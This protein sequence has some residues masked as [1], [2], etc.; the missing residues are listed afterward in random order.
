MRRE[1]LS[2]GKALFASFLLIFSAVP[3]VGKTAF[4]QKA[5]V[6]LIGDKA[7]ILGE[8]RAVTSG[9]FVSDFNWS[10]T[11]KTGLLQRLDV[12]MTEEV[13][14]LAG[15]E[16]SPSST[17][18]SLM[19]WNRN[20]GALT[21]IRRYDSRRELVWDYGVMTDDR[22][23][24]TVSM[25]KQSNTETLTI[26]NPNG[27][28]D[29]MKAGEGEFLGVAHAIRSSTILIASGLQGDGTTA[30][31][32]LFDSATRR[33]VPINIVLK[34]EEMIFL[35]GGPD[36]ISYLFSV[37][38][39][40]DK[41]RKYVRYDIRANALRPTTKEEYFAALASVEDSKLPMVAELDDETLADGRH[42]QSAVLRASKPSAEPAKPDRPLRFA[43][44]TSKVELAPAGDGVLYTLD[45][46]LV[47]R[48]IATAKRELFDKVDGPMTKEL[49][50]SNAKQIGIGL[51]MYASDY[52][53]CLPGGDLRESVM[54][55]VKDEGPFNGFVS[56]FQPGSNL[57][58]IN[59][60]ANTPLGFIKGPGGTATVYADGS[61]RWKDDA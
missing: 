47:Y 50:I 55:Y 35:V 61:V 39:K 34:K 25:D 21:L 8:A 20:S 57:N 26:T 12:R 31:I 28:P 22:T 52:D 30:R 56:V 41:V 2:Q 60:P 15:L 48:E 36:G 16:D 19:L 40:N 27:S 42:T 24:F 58:S 51:L 10:P 37:T 3:V 4:E 29:V 54:P 18:S 23:V 33:W 13:N 43:T 46:M 6:A 7:Y 32:S 38:N 1:L 53:D 17:M 49:A 9:G 59:D 45:G 11:G 5:Y 44:G 14:W